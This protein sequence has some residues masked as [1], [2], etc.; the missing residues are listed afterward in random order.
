[1]LVKKLVVTAVSVLALV[2]VPVEASAESAKPGYFGMGYSIDRESGALVVEQIV[3]G[4][5]ADTGELRVGDVVRRI[6]GAEVRFVAYRDAV[7]FLRS[8]AV[9]GK[10][11]SLELLRHT[12]PVSVTLVAEPRPADLDVQ[13]EQVVRCLDGFVREPQNDWLEELQSVPP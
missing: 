13:N 7:T 5:P 12:R 3:P 9:V 8:V 6:A 10:P 4:S 11:I 1:M 2:G